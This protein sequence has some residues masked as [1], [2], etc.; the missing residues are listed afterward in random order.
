MD[1]RRNPY[2]PGAGLR[3]PKLAGRDEEL[4]RLE[5]V[6]DRLAEGAHERSLIASGLRGVGKTVLLLEFDAIATERGWATSE[7]VEAGSQPDFRLTFARM[8][9]R[10]LRSLSLKHRVKDRTRRALGVVGS[11]S[12]GAPLPG[13]WL[14]LH[15]EPAA[16]A[17]DSGDPE[18]DLAELLR[19]VGDVALAA[20]TGALFL[21]D[22]MHNLDGPSLAAVCLSF[23][24]LAKL[25]LPV[26]LV[27]AGLPDL[28][29]RLFAAKPYADR[30]FTHRELGRLRAP[31]ARAALVGPAGVHGLG[32]EPDAVAAVVA[33][34]AGY[35]Y[36]LQ[37]YGRELW[38]HVDG[39]PVT[40]A[41]VATVREVVR[42]ALARDF[43][44][45]RF[46]LATDAEQRYL[47]AMAALGAPPYRTRAVA[48]A[49]G[50]A[51]QRAVSVQRDGLMKKGLA[52]SPRRAYVDFTV[53][54]F[55]EFVREEHPLA[56][57]DE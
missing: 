45:T 16:G 11:F 40:A 53:P 56:G 17:A 25:G 41:D 30:L 47:A 50:A 18:E 37:E 9:A 2:T 21:L 19:A 48:E 1:K 46:G 7:V 27:G 43:F 20:R 33:E 5:L 8:A 15:V 22:E 13:G 6:V 42:D 31:A 4:E 38:N 54:L 12:L 26:A 39:S 29:G 52:W 28:P 3:P 44:G 14:G 23:Q 24:A 35:P 10:V 49:F 34:S 51:D 55:A 32:F 57:F 36:F